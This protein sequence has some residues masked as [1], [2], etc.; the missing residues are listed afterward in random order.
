MKHNLLLLCCALLTLS[1]SAFGQ[2]TLTVSGTVTDAQTAEE[3]IGVSIYVEGTDHRGTITDLDGHYQLSNVPA[4]ATLNF[5]Y[6]GYEPQRVKVDG[7]SVIHI[8]LG[9]SSTAIEEVVVVGYT[10]QRKRDVLGAINKVD[11]ED[12]IKVPVPSAELALQ[13]RVPG[14]QVSSSTGAPGANISVRV[15]GVGSINSSNDPLYIVDGIPVENG[16]NAISANDI[17]DIVVLKDA[18]S[19]AIY[20]S[21]GSNGIVL[22]TTK[23]G[24]KGQ[25][26][27]SYNTQVGFQ[28]HGNLIDMVNTQDYIT[29]YNEATLTDNGISGVSQRELIQGDYLNGLANENHLK[30]LFQTAIIQTH[31]LSVSGGNDKTTYMMSANYFDQEGIIKNSDYNR[32][33]IRSNVNS[34]IKPWLTVGMNI[35]AGQT[36]TNSIP[37][38]GDG[39]GNSEGGSAIRYALF[40]N[41]AIPAY[42]A[43]GNY[44]DKP[45]EYFGNSVYDIF[46]GDGYNPLGVAY[47]TDR[48]RKENSFI[49]SGNIVVKFP[50]NIIWKTVMGIDYLNGSNWVFN[51]NWG[52]NGRINSPNS[53]SLENYNRS[54]WNVNSVLNYGVTLNEVHNLSAMVGVEAL[55]STTSTVNNYDQNF[56][57]D[58]VQIGK[59]LDEQRRQQSEGGETYALASFFASANYNFNQKYYLSATLRRDGTSRF[60]GDNKWGMFYSV[61]GGWNLESEGFMENLEFID[62]MKLRAGW[63]T[64]GNQHV[65]NYA[66]SD[67]ISQ[68]YNYPFGDTSNQGY[69]QT[70]LGN[71][72]LK[73]ETSEQLNIGL[74]MAFLNHT[75]GF[76]VDYFHKKSKDMLMQA[77]LPSSFG[78]LQAPWINNGSL[79]NTGV[80]MEVFYRQKYK[81][82]GF[83]VRVNGG[84]L[85]NKV[86]EMDGAMSGGRVDEGI[87]AVRTE[88]SYP[89]SSFYM[90]EMEGI[91]QNTAEILTSAYQGDNIQPGDVK[92]RDVNGDGVIDDQDR[93]HV[94]S[95]IPKFTTGINLS[96][97]WKNLDISCFFQGAFGHKT[98]VQVF[99][100]IEGFYRGFGVTQ[101]YF[102]ERWTGE[103]TS[104]TQPRASWKSKSNNARV[105]TRF[106]EDAS[107]LRLKNLQIGYT[108][109]N[110][111]RFGI[112][113]LRVY[114]SGTNLLTFTKY[115]G[116]DPEMTVS[117]NSSGEGD[118]A[119][120]IDWGTY[121][122]ARSYTV[123]LNL[124]F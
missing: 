46:F 94:G 78:Y 1:L 86:L 71:E 5:S 74:D 55:R 108:I 30:N 117:A 82:G 35:I 120:G 98:Y 96:G 75:L 23:K 25:A 57:D 80:D 37:S 14:V 70:K 110:T 11:S 16:L 121:P 45:S 87:Y 38:S 118:R 2:G 101:R 19:T 8:T 83:E 52:T 95:A 109:P 10:V 13:G 100:D 34:D 17:E 113:N 119:M 51:R 7:R 123:G 31:E 104:N 29:L 63:G 68:N 65:G 26:R 107:Y 77:T 50:Q 12:L 9:V 21:R 64:A 54:T 48:R 116:L 85:K 67:M 39:Y 42:D 105:S 84:Y 106:L 33:S 20:G 43:E 24:N 47:M 89:V 4:N 73:W 66:Y 61:S 56:V 49:G 88:A 32:V 90:L 6:I 99:H 92:Y 97:Y 40:R 69:A 3:L 81:T 103:G 93:V 18:S 111:Q 44:V 22:I 15:R 79:L 36:K 114:V 53:L 122:V 72:D 124:T 27:I 102:D 28:R 58:L 59:G 76:S 112:E 60:V 41:P 115:P 62:L 91:F